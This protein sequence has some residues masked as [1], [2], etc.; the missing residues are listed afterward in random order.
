[1]YIHEY[2]AKNL[3]LRYGV[4]V[5]PFAIATNDEEVR[6]AITELGIEEAVIKVQIHAGGRGKAGG[7]KFAKTPEEIARYASELIGMRITNNQTGP[8]GVVAESVLIAPP[9]SIQKEFYLAATIDRSKG[10]P[11]LIASPEGGMEIEEIAVEK[12]EKILK[13]SFG[14]D[15]SIRGYHLTELVKF[16]GWSGEL[17]KEG[18]QLVKQ[19]AK[20]FI[21][22]DAA[23]LEI[24]PLVL[25]DE[26][27]LSAIDAKFSVDDNALYRQP[28]IAQWYDPTQQ[29]PNEVMA[30]EFDLAYIGLDGEIGCLVNGAGL[31]M[32]TMD[33]I[34]HYGGEPANFLDVGGGASKEVVAHGFKIILLDPKVK[35]IFVNIFGGIMDCGVLAQGIVEAS[36]LDQVSV[37]LVV[38]MEGTNVEIGKQILKES[39]LNIITA[40]TMADGAVKAV[41][42]ARETS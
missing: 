18:K 11:I 22:T 1:M 37:P 10:V 30:K 36:R 32:A 25:T 17:A 4:P 39:G 27:R 19:L 24:N 38:R 41:Q 12:P 8:Q 26:N 21:E 29:T 40:E 34:H 42:A 28:A 14:H 6:K 9:V 2:Q 7:V 3:L 33:I 31:A 13:I 35:A 15:G 5:P 16:M 20:A 23:L